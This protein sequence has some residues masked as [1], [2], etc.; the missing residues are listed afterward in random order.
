MS[1]EALFDVSPYD[2]GWKRRPKP[3]PKAEPQ[4]WPTAALVADGIAWRGVSKRTPGVVH[5]FTG[6]RNDVGGQVSWCGLVL[7]PHA[8]AAGETILACRRCVENGA[9]HRRIQPT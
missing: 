3:K 9:P 2:R 4:E 5:A 7:V 1:D 8:I 6:K